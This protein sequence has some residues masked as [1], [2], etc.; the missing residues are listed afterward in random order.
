MGGETWQQMLSAEGCQGEQVPVMFLVALLG[1]SPPVASLAL[2]CL[3][4][5]GW[6][7]RPGNSVAGLLLKELEMRRGESW[8]FQ[9]RHMG[10]TRPG[11]GIQSS[12]AAAM[13]RMVTDGLE[14]E[15]A[16]LDLKSDSDLHGLNFIPSG[17]AIQIS[18]LT[19]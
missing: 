13:V 16:T 9:G 19:E 1:H 17:D 18:H 2:K 15:A 8:G 4:S 14:Q 7:Q 10:P 6:K 11:A 3:Q 5:L 12:Q